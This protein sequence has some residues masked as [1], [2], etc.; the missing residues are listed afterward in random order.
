MCSVAQQDKPFAAA[1]K[2][3]FEKLL[4][5]AIVSTNS[6]LQTTDN[7]EFREL[8][9]SLRSTVPVPCRRILSDRILS[10]QVQ[11][12]EAKK[13]GKLAKSRGK[14]LSIS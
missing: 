11:Q 8:L 9:Q 14:L 7:L 1:E 12:V 4:L 6:A 5:R 13:L 2:A 10:T 3:E